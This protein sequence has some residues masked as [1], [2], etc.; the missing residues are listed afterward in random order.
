MTIVK[1]SISGLPHQ[2]GIWARRTQHAV[3]LAARAGRNIFAAGLTLFAVTAACA[4]KVPV[5][6]QRS[7]MKSIA[8]EKL[9]TNI[10]VDGLLDERAWKNARSIAKLIQQS[11]H[12]GQ[13]TVYN[14]D[15]RVLVTRDNLYFGFT[16]TDPHPDRI[17]IHT[18]QRDGV[19]EGDDFVSIVLDTYGDKRT[20]YF[21]SVNAA[22][23]RVDGLVAAP[24]NIT[25]DWDGIW[26]AQ[27]ARSSAGWSAEIVIPSRSLNFTQALNEWGVNFER[28][29]ARDRTVLRWSSPTLDSFFYDLSRAGV[30]T[31]IEDLRQGRGLEISPFVTGRTSKQFELDHRNYSGQ[32]GLDASWRITPQLAAV[33]TFNTD[34]AETE[35]D[36]RQLNVTRFPLFF[37][38]RRAFFSEGAN[39]YEFATGLDENSFIPFFSRRIGLFE[40]V[41]SPIDAGVKLNGRVGRWNLGMLDVQ[42]RDNQFA[43]GSNM[44]V[45]RASYD[46]SKALRL[47]TIVTNGSPNGIQRN[48]LVGFDSVWRTSNFRANK[49][50]LIGSWFAFTEG[51]LPAGNRT[52]WG[53]RIDYPND[54][55]ECNADTRHF[56]TAMLPALGFL[57]RPGTRQYEAAC[58]FKPRPSREGKLSFI[59]Q[60]FLEVDTERVDNYA[61][62]KTETWSVAPKPNIQFDSGDQISFTVNF[63]GEQLLSPFEVSKGVVLPVGKYQ[64][65]RYEIEAETGSQRSW[66]GGGKVEWGEFFNGT[67]LQVSSK[68]NWTSPA[69]TL[70]TGLQVEH[71]YGRLPQG[72]FVQRLWQLNLAY[73]FNPNLV[74]TSFL[75]YDNETQGVGNNMR[76]H[77]T[78]KPGNDLFVVWQREWK[79]VVQSPSDAVVA[80]ESD[81]IAVK[82]RWTFRR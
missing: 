51:D 52:A 48:T 64:F 82:L 14:T 44:F 67:L 43:P 81:V 1:S 73:A 41:R 50:L 78:I 39:Q 33:V 28:N 21:F 75:Q 42:T 26:D 10:V 27:I 59:R 46:V 31:G 24:E 16:C 74:L 19:F 8:A 65:N 40:G 76:L 80:P 20:G 3:L 57:R 71:N 17:S 30:M 68:I 70:Q 54:R 2:C 22:G 60:T 63:Q 69:G 53:A 18:K 49:N 12:T 77:W 5:I 15:V 9:H 45:G 7:D 4:Q 11:P 38:E 72:N 61:T 79:Q 62:G 47:G 32:A 56:G 37:P 58:S 34:F 6:T 29:I 66:V 25:L 55:W 35:V 36:S 13:P 23:A